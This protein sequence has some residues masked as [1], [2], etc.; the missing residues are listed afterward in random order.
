M[1]CN[2]FRSISIVI[3]LLKTAFYKVS[4]YEAE[5]DPESRP[6]TSSRIALQVARKINHELQLNGTKKLKLLLFFAG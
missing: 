5:C 1:F 3:R 4:D 6:V 2:I